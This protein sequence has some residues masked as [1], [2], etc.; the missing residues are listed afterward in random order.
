MTHP[1]RG[2]AAAKSKRLHAEQAGAWPAA[3]AGH[4]PQHA[5][6]SSSAIRKGVEECHSALH[7]RQGQFCC[8][9]GHRSQPA[10]VPHLA[11]LSGGRRRQIHHRVSSMV[12]ANPA[13]TKADVTARTFCRFHKRW[14]TRETGM[15]E[16]GRQQI[17]LT[18]PRIK[19]HATSTATIVATG[20]MASCQCHC[21]PG[22]QLP[23]G[24]RAGVPCASAAPGGLCYTRSA[25]RPT[26]GVLLHHRGYVEQPCLRSALLLRLRRQRR[27]ARRGAAKLRFVRV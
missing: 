26:H 21:C 6:A 15:R 19:P 4:A 25:D 22:Q 12:P 14:G 24:E 5:L 2:A 1:V 17:R 20:M 27:R 9:P 18:A 11:L 8:K 10:G 16:A 3:C 7:R 13:T 23:Y